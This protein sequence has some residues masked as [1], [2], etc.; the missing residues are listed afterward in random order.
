MKRKGQFFILGAVL[1]ISLFFFGLPER[2]T[3]ITQETDDMV[4]LH[5]NILRE[6]SYAY[7]NIL[8]STGPN[9]NSIGNLTN[10][11]Y[12][13]DDLMSQRLINSS[14]MWISIWNITDYG[15][16]I[17]VGNYMKEDITLRFYI[18]SFIFDE[19]CSTERYLIVPHNST[20]YTNITSVEYQYKL[21]LD[22]DNNKVD[23]YMEYL[24]RD[25]TSLHTYLKMKRGDNIIIDEYV[26]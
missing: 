14:I 10:F 3:L 24:A 13:V 12:Y 2:D 4:F 18:C 1:L 23:D 15:I 9:E 22:Y 17:T 16:N 20:N 26:G 6:Y 8:N 19:L 11:T 7:N 21:V 25:K 5:D